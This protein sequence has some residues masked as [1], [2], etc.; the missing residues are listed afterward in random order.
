M[1]IR[2]R[3]VGHGDEPPDQLLA[4]PL[5][6]R[7]HPGRQ[8]DA[9]RGSMRELGWVKSVLVNKRTGYVLDGHARVEESL[10][11]KLKTIPVTYVDLS[12]EEERIAL[13]VLDP[14]TEFAI[15]D[16]DA[17]AALLSEVTTQDKDL[18]AFLA[19][20]GQEPEATILPGADLD[21]A[22]EPP[23]DPIT[24]PGDLIELGRHR[25][26][27][28]DSTNIQHVER[29]MAGTLADMVWTDPPYNVA[30]EGAAG[31]IQNDN[32]GGEQFRQ[33]L[34]DAFACACAATKPGGGIYV[35]FADVEVAN[36]AGAFIEAGWKLAQ[37]LIWVKSSL[38]LGRKD[39]H[40][41]HEPILY[42]WK[43]GAAHTWTGDRSQT[44]VLEFNK[45]SRNGEHPTM[46]PVELVA[47]CIGNS[48]TQGQIVLDLFGGSGTTL[49]ACESLGRSVRLMEIDP[50]Y[51]D[52][53]V[54]RW[55]KV[56]GQKAKRP[57]THKELE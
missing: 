1:D 50:R 16:Q 4:N 17:L 27:C 52:V 31:K 45:P 57:E 11:Q 37:M 42:G 49:V 33:F 34:R 18:Q 41:K 46:K 48:S 8:M 35:S 39:Y 55:E 28:G 25:L 56:T 47:Y 51:C 53:I 7:R 30:Y 10:R 15:R 26:L 29:L 36:F 19:T 14:I 12:P 23:P 20:L 24:K 32:M 44:T 54:N 22:G 21:E 38:V 13:A 3:I 5:N 2:S 40:F 6:F 43:E 9:L